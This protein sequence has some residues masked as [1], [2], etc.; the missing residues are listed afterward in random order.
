MLPAVLFI[1]VL[2]LAA[3]KMPLVKKEEAKSN[4][5]RPQNVVVILFHNLLI[6]RPW[7]SAYISRDQLHVSL[8]STVD[9]FACLLQKSC[10]LKI[11]SPTYPISEGLNHP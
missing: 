9:H 3:G 8:H 2:I 4:I 5:R 7:P 10:I 11:G 6:R 1:N